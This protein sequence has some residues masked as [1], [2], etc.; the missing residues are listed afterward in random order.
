V[1]RTDLDHFLVRLLT[2]PLGEACV[3]FGASGL[4]QTA[5]G[6]LADENVLEAIGRLSP[7]R[8]ALFPCDEVAQEQVVANVL[9]VVRVVLR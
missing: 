6:D 7:D 2:Q 9:E 1:I 4:P 3:V 8:R 5:V